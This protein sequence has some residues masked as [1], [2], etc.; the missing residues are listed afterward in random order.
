MNNNLIDNV[1]REAISYAV[2]YSYIIDDAYAGQVAEMKSPI[3]LGIRYADW[4]YNAATFDVIRARQILVDNGICSY[5][6]NEDALWID[7]ANN[8]PIAI[9]NYAELFFNRFSITI[10]DLLVDNLAKIGIK[11]LVETLNWA[12][13][14][15]RMVFEPNTIDLYFL[16]W[17][18]DYN[19]P[20]AY[21]NGLFS[22]DSPTTNF[23]QT[24]D[25]YLQN[26]MDTALT[27]TDQNIRRTIYSEI[28]QYLVEDLMPLVYLCV[29]LN[30][31][32]YNAKFT[33]YQSNVLDKLWFYTIIPPEVPSGEIFE[34][35][36]IVISEG[37]VLFGSAIFTVFE[38]ILQ[39]KIKDHLFTWEIMQR[40]ELNKCD[41]YIGLGEKGW[42]TVI[43]SKS[44]TSSYL[45]AFGRGITF[46][47]YF[48]Y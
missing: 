6:V 26:L 24:N 22:D 12:D 3:P 35:F 16:S 1:M 9:Y 7:A 18:P 46:T 15:E 8:N 19:D 14:I 23:A 38:E 42:I 41:I 47:G 44:E 21:L 25:P 2:N 40:Y 27:E 17:I 36:G 13:F 32:V 30:Y 10:G 28:Q 4:T 48:Y 33:G 45:F 20:S 34:G 11:I 5:D 31:D 39:L 37:D 29:N 43:I